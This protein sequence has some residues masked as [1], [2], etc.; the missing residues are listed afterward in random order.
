MNEQFVWPVI[1]MEKTGGNI[2]ALR[3][4]NGMSVKDL[5]RVFGFNSPQAIYKWQWGETLPDVANLLVMTR[6]W[7]VRVEDILVLTHQDVLFFPG[8][9][10]GKRLVRAFLS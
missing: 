10:Y 7:N 1:D 6:L 8:H 9:V 2:R 4:R 5:Q 3:E